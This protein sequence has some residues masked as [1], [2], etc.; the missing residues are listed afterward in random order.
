MP[1]KGIH[2]CS[3]CQATEYNKKG[4]L[5]CIVTEN[6]KVREHIDESEALKNV[7]KLTTFKGWDEITEYALK[8]CP[9]C[10]GIPK[11]VH[12]GN[13]HTKSRKIKIKCTKCRCERIDASIRFDFGW[14]EKIAV[15][16]WN[17]RP[18]CT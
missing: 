14:L 17:Q 16:H 9:F 11:A 2:P 4:E 13:E 10:G 5:I 8:P 3:G 15:D 18:S 7:E 1:K 6:Q 12:I